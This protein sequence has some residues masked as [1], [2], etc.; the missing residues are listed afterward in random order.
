MFVCAMDVD[1]PGTPQ[2]QKR[3]GK[4]QTTIGTFQPWGTSAACQI[5]RVEKTTWRWISTCTFTTSLASECT[6]NTSI[7]TTTMFSF[8]TSKIYPI[9]Y[10]HNAGA[11]ISKIQKMKS[12]S[13]KKFV[14]LISRKTPEKW[15]QCVHHHWQN[16]WNAWGSS[17]ERD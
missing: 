16:G 1:E 4:C 7:H 17:N 12:I 3:W 9:L 15:A 11:K 10:M 5:K 13:R 2:L 6:Y 8:L 14:K